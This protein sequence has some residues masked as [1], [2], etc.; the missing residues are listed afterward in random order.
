MSGLAITR[1]A[2]TICAGSIELNECG[3]AIYD[4]EAV[5]LLV[6]GLIPRLHGPGGA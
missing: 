3:Y 5:T 1:F 6:I 2:T 4:R